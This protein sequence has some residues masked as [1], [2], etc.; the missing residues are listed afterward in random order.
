M[1]K[2]ILFRVFFASDPVQFQYTFTK[3]VSKVYRIQYT[4]KYDFLLKSS[5]SLRKSTKN[6]KVYPIHFRYTFGESVSK[7]YWT[8]GAFLMKMI[9][10]RSKR[11]LN[12]SQFT[13]Q[14]TL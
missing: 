3:S 8:V 7:V 2:T 14:F 12:Y 11:I 10:K 1:S 13:R 5:I 4:L 6:A 9:S